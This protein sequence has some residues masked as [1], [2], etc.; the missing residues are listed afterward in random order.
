MHPLLEPLSLHLRANEQT[1]RLEALT[2]TGAFHILLLRLNRPQLVERRLA[3]RLRQLL[4]ESFQ[5]LQNEN[6]DLR[7]RVLLLEG[8][9]RELNRHRAWE[10]GPKE[11]EPSP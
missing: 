5:L 10:A 3:Q 2:P 4:S 6:S 11:E 7:V 8:Y 9:L 1:G